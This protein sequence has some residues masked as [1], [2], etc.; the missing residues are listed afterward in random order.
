MADPL[1]DAARRFADLS[2]ERHRARQARLARERAERAE[3]EANAAQAALPDAVAAA[4][5]RARS[6]RGPTG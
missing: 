3:R 5:A 4:L 6:K 2:R 1:S